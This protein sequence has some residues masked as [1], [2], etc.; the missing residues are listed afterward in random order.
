[1]EVGLCI[2]G[3]KGETYVRVQRESGCESLYLRVDCRQWIFMHTL[4]PTHFTFSM[5]SF[6]WAK[7]VTEP[8]TSLNSFRWRLDCSMFS[9]IVV[10]LERKS[11]F[12]TERNSLCVP[13]TGG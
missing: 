11:R 2:R 5:S 13:S 4:I 1:M 9:P 6:S 8:N 7:R 12:K 10:I 3:R